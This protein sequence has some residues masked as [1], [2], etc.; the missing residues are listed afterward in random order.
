M[1]LRFL[2]DRFDELPATRAL[3]EQL[4]PAGG[5]LAIGGLP[6][7]SAVVLV[8]ALAERLPQRVVVVVTATT[9]DAERWL[10]DA[11]TLL[12]PVTALY[13]QR[14]GLGAEEPHLE[15]AGERIETV[16]ALL[17]GAVRVLVTTARASGES[18][19]LTMARVTAPPALARS[20]RARRSGLLPDWEMAIAAAELRR[21]GA[22]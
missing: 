2:L 8:A 20:I 1:A 21:K 11:Q 4:P 10:A 19:S 13:P 18:S 3:V 6:G 16:E 14:E 22:V 5:R 17:S 12:G 7:S 15:I 9:A